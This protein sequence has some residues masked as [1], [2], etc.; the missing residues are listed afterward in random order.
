MP[1]DT[2]ELKSSN[3]M[4]ATVVIMGFICVCLVFIVE[5]LGS[6]LELSIRLG[7]VTNGPLL[8]LFTLGMIFP[9][10]NAKVSHHFVSIDLIF[11]IKF[12]F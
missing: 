1:P 6:V 2:S 3:I 10:A 11:F 4:K 8:G 7:A 5:K 9:S 12:Y